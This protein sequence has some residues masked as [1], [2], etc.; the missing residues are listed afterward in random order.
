MKNLQLVLGVD[1]DNPLFSI[2]SQERPPR[3]HNDLKMAIECADAIGANKV[4]LTHLSH[5]LD[6]WLMEHCEALPKHILIAYDGLTFNQSK[7]V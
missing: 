7:R 4:I 1:K 2:Y 6:L 3:N 5:D